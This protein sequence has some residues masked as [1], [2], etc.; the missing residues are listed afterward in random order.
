MPPF[1]LPHHG[2]GDR[3]IKEAFAAVLRGNVPAAGPRLAPD[4]GP[5]RIGFVASHPHE[6]GFLRFAGGI[7][8]RLDPARFRVV[9]IGSARGL[10]ALRAGIPRPDAEFVALPD[11]L[12]GAV[13]ALASARCDVLYHW[14]VG[15]DPLNYA[16]PMARAAPAQCTSWGTHVTSGLAEL[17]FYLSSELIEAPGAES[18]YTEALV[19]FATLPTYRVRPPRPDPPA[20]RSEFG[21]P[22]GAN[23]YAC[24]QRLAKFHPDFD[25]ILAGILR[26]DPAGLILAAEDRGGHSAA[27]LRARLDATMPAVADRV[28]FLPRHDFAGYLRL[29]SLA[30]V[31]LDP[32]PYGSGH[33][34]YDALGLGVPLVTLPGTFKVS[35]YGLAYARKLGLPELV[36][37]SPAHYVALAGRLGTDRAYRAEIAG[38]LAT[39][40]P[41]LFEDVRTVREHERFFE[42]AA[43]R[44]PEEQGG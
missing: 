28:L 11:D 42:H 13:A 7:A 19:R 1:N 2:R 38:R 39:A 40:S 34:G 24:L 16:L 10:P 44:A 4:G 5:P 18:H 41:V 30:T 43:G 14:Q 31:A 8:Q 23:L 26:R 33:T 29:L 12:P 20:R 22:E 3:R 9:V 6:G 27:R 35:R 25:P 15:T 17:D 37:D 21:L 36:A 32:V